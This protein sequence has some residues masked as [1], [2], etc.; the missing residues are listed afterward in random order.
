MVLALPRLGI[1]EIQR[2]WLP[3]TKGQDISISWMVK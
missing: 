1:L 2:I 3:L